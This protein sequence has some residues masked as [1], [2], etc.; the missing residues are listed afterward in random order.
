LTPINYLPTPHLASYLPLITI[1]DRG[2]DPMTHTN[3]PDPTTTVVRHDPPNPGAVDPHRGWAGAVVS[4]IA[5]RVTGELIRTISEDGST[6]EHEAH[7]NIDGH[8]T[9]LRFADIQAGDPAALRQLSVVS[10]MLADELA[11]AAQT[12]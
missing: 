12:C 11:A 2:V 6:I 7:I 3:I 1:D 5:G 8:D 9:A 10:A 4:V